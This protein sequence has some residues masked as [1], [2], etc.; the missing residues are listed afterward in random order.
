MMGHIEM[1]ENGPAVVVDAGPSEGTYDVDPKTGLV[2]IDGTTYDA[3]GADSINEY[4]DETGYEGDIAPVFGADDK[5]FG[6]IETESKTSSTGR[7][8]WKKKSA[9]KK[10]K[11]AKKKKYDKT[12][13]FKVVNDVFEERTAA[14]KKEIK[15]IEGNKK[16]SPAKKKLE[17]AKR[18]KEMEK[19][20]TEAEENT[21]KYNNIKGALEQATSFYTVDGTSTSKNI[22]ARLT[23]KVS[24]A[25]EDVEGEP[26][27]DQSYIVVASNEGAMGKKDS[28]TKTFVKE[29]YGEGARTFFFTNDGMTTASREAIK[30][31]T[32]GE[33]GSIFYQQADGSYSTDAPSKA[34]V[35][36]KV[37]DGLSQYNDSVGLTDYDA[38]G[39][40][41]YRDLFRDIFMNDGRINTKGYVESI[42]TRKDGSI[43]HN[44]TD[45][46]GGQ[47]H[48]KDRLEE[49]VDTKGFE[50]KKSSLYTI[51]NLFQ[52]GLSFNAKQMKKDVDA[53]GKGEDIHVDD[54]AQFR[55][56]LLDFINK[57]EKIFKMRNAQK[58]SGTFNLLFTEYESNGETFT[59]LNPKIMEVGLLAGVAAIVQSKGRAEEDIV[60]NEDGAVSKSVFSEATLREFAAAGAWEHVISS[61]IG[62]AVRKELGLKIESNANST[63]S[64]DVLT[65]RLDSEI[66]AAV[67]VTMKETGIVTTKE[68]DMVKKGQKTKTH[69][70]GHFVD[71][72]EDYENIINVSNKLT[73]MMTNTNQ[74]VVPFESVDDAA[75]A[76]TYYI[77]NKYGFAYDEGS[78]VRNLQEMETAV[79]YVMN[80]DL[81]ELFDKMDWQIEGALGFKDETEIEKMN[82]LHQAR[83]ESINDGAS[84]DITG[85]K[86]FRDE[87]EGETFHP[88]TDQQSQGRVRHNGKEYNIQNSKLHRFLSVFKKPVGIRGKKMKMRMEDTLM[89][90]MGV[91]IDKVDAKTL[92][93]F[94]DALFYGKKPAN[95]KDAAAIKSINEASAAL[96]RIE[97]GSPADGDIE[98]VNSFS[99]SH[100]GIGTMFG[101][102]ELNKYRAWLNSGG[103]GMFKTKLLTEQDGRTNGLAINMMQFPS[104]S[105]FGTSTRNNLYGMTGINMN[106]KKPVQEVRLD[107]DQQDTYLV[108]DKLARDKIF[109]KEGFATGLGK[110]TEQF[111]SGILGRDA[112]KELVLPGT[113]ASSEAS[114]NEG[115]A[116]YIYTAIQDLVYIPSDIDPGSQEYKDRANHTFAV[117]NAIFGGAKTNKALLD[118]I[119]GDSSIEE[120]MEYLIEYPF[121][122]GVAT[123]TNLKNFLETNLTK[124]YT[125]AFTKLFAPMLESQTYMK[126]GAEAM[127][128]GMD[129]LIESNGRVKFLADEL[130]SVRAN[131]KKYRKQLEAELRNYIPSIKGFNVTKDSSE[132]LKKLFP[133]GLKEVDIPL[134]ATE[135]TEN[136]KKTGLTPITQLYRKEPQWDRELKPGEKLS[137]YKA[138]VRG[139]IMEDGSRGAPVSPIQSLDS[140]IMYVAAKIYEQKTGEKIDFTSIFDAMMT[141]LSNTDVIAQSYNEAFILVNQEV[142]LAQNMYDAVAAKKQYAVDMKEDP[143]MR[144]ADMTSEQVADL[145]LY[146]KELDKF[147]ESQKNI[148]YKDNVTSKRAE[149]GNNIQSVH[150]LGSYERGESGVFVNDKFT[151]TNT[152][153]FQFKDIESLDVATKGNIKANIE[154]MPTELQ[155]QVDPDTGLL[156]TTGPMKI[157][158][159]IAYLKAFH[160]GSQA[161]KNLIALSS[162]DNVDAM[163][164]GIEVELNNIGDF[165]AE[166]QSDGS[167]KYLPNNEAMIKINAARNEYFEN[168]DYATVLFHETMHP[169][170]NEMYAN[171]KKT[172]DGF[173]KEIYRV[174]GRKGMKTFMSDAG[175]DLEFF[176]G[177]TK[178]YDRVNLLFNSMSKSDIEK[179]KE[180]VVILMAEPTVRRKFFDMIGISEKMNAESSVEAQ[181][182]TKRIVGLLKSLFEAIKST[183][184]KVLFAGDLKKTGEPTF[185]PSTAY[186]EFLTASNDALGSFE[187]KQRL[188]KDNNIMSYSNEGET[189]NWTGT[190]F[191]PVQNMSK[192]FVSYLVDKGIG[193]Y[194]RMAM[195]MTGDSKF[196]SNQT[197]KLLGGHYHDNW[198]KGILAS[199]NSD[200]RMDDSLGNKMAKKSSEFQDKATK[201]REDVEAMVKHMMGRYDEGMEQDAHEAVLD[202][203]LQALYVHSTNDLS[204]LL[205]GRANMSSLIDQYESDLNLSE[206]TKTHAKRL[207][208]YMMT[209]ETKLDSKDK[210]DLIFNVVVMNDKL[211][212]NMTDSQK[213]HLDAYITLLALQQSKK[214]ASIQKMSLADAMELTSYAHSTYEHGRSLFDAR[215]ITDTADQAYRRIKGWTPMQTAQDVEIMYVQTEKEKNDMLMDTQE[216]W[217]V[218]ED[219]GKNGAIL[220]RE[221]LGPRYQQGYIPTQ[222]EKMMGINSGSDISIKT[223]GAIRSSSNLMPL[224]NK[225]GKVIS[226]RYIMNKDRRKELLGMDNKIS[227]GLGTME[228]TAIRRTAAYSFAREIKGNVVNVNGK[229]AKEF[230]TDAKDGKGKVPLM[231]N[232]TPKGFAA[233]DPEVRNMYKRIEHTNLLPKFLAGSGK[234]QDGR[235]K[236]NITHIYAPAYDQVMGFYEYSPEKYT[237]AMQKIFR[238][239]KGFIRTFKSNAVVKSA[240][241]ISINIMAGIHLLVLSGVPMLPRTDDEGNKFPGAIRIIAD[242]LFNA[243]K[244]LDARTEMNRIEFRLD[245]IKGQPN[246]AAKAAKLKAR[247]DEIRAK[248]EKNPLAKVMDKQFFQSMTG[249]L[250]TTENDT[251]HF[252]NFIWETLETIGDKTEN[253]FYAEQITKVVMNGMTAGTVGLAGRIS[254]GVGKILPDKIGGEYADKLGEDIAAMVKKN[255]GKPLDQL[256]ELW[257]REGSILNRE[258]SFAMQMGDFMGRNAAYQWEV[259]K[260]TEAG[261]TDAEL[262]TVDDNAEAAAQEM[263]VDYRKNLPRNINFISS[264]VPIF[265]FA[266]FFLN[267]QPVLWKTM[268]ENPI[269]FGISAATS[270]IGIPGVSE[271]VPEGINMID[272]SVAFGFG[273]RVDPTP[274]LLNM[275]F[276]PPAYIPESYEAIAM[277]FG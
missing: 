161:T 97:S 142:N 86:V 34:K 234:S 153:V 276:T 56:V 84:R 147:L 125:N 214:L 200:A 255:K 131:D 49:D 184:G 211:K 168:I 93:D 196:I 264:I 12:K 197:K 67:L 5:A 143:S 39:T 144:P 17:I 215:D 226:Y 19:L 169:V 183:I 53:L 130:K 220:T 269:K 273:G 194:D 27:S 40:D 248:F 254:A 117:M 204:N 71:I 219:F 193:Y 44:E 73:G 124:P 203:D 30:M 149:L 213:N 76:S 25:V 265:P 192:H 62:S 230:N 138:R 233:L 190:S 113:Y 132:E 122:Y 277:P 60:K 244:M 267:I 160:P 167:I 274:D 195:S 29:A 152:G 70:K 250:M 111:L 112:V 186:H 74:V 3:F 271:A 11:T 199:T 78:Y 201:A 108:V 240:T 136:Q 252:E 181:S 222:A 205:S 238:M 146:I 33:L 103:Q 48:I 118:K 2:N 170:I 135:Q 224:Y 46:V 225:D 15:Q 77:P 59:M 259:F 63:E 177:D 148:T 166:T 145:D 7:K 218:A 45:R 42:E 102:Q 90:W 217:E 32:S 202:A 54:V 107:N 126:S 185:T 243:R 235:D 115:L 28:A 38:D 208:N 116:D 139:F 175:L 275:A 253:K 140:A 98:L 155:K 223:A 187:K 268:L 157:N 159:V 216:E 119:N 66:G 242:S 249:E 261:M 245:G 37:D 91:G 180:A 13:R 128:K 18:N 82:V 206:E 51:P 101:L 257:G 156:K 171:N 179:Q 241:V 191:D 16:Y 158:D 121:G 36:S 20:T 262:E 99:N 258:G 8:E 151:G 127:F 150:Q 14:L 172:F 81:A 123:N 212:L 173:F 9:P 1:G 266:K 251:N 221:K 100:E 162:V 141:D 164:E 174:K 87:V 114:L 232:F 68:I 57:G 246:F 41:T 176:N 110:D 198:I 23:E 50:K 92:T 188:D 260:N 133:K 83:Q 182:N 210:G 247:H 89:F 65:K 228:S 6:D 72:A 256:A 10:G 26:I 88:S 231:V 105:F 75:A 229:N 55:D 163:F 47:L 95:E 35:D 79:D 272:T 61:A 64:N 24:D 85:A 207:A 96:E 263:F 239:L 94:G 129:A 120:K 22:K 21:L 104:N 52:L 227:S 165:T 178:M 4:A 209:Y 154:K 106:D 270:V 80:D 134:I 189:N 137:E 58:T 237:R 236:T 43:V 31:L 109:G 69:E